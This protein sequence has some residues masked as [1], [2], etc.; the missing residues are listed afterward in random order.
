MRRV[1]IGVAPPPRRGLPGTAEDPPTLQFKDHW[2][3]PP[4]FS[5]FVTL[6]VVSSFWK[7]KERCAVVFSSFHIKKKTHLQTK[8]TH[9][10]SEEHQRESGGGGFG[11]GRREGCCDLER[12]TANILS[13][14]QSGSAGGYW[15]QAT[16]AGVKALR[17]EVCCSW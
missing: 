16:A 15:F 3:Q 13:M 11:C 2:P 8:N 5:L 17:L 1:T 14:H 6:S 9:L 12:L 10:S 7:K 4:A